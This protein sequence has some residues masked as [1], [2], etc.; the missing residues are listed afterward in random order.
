MKKIKPGKSN[1]KHKLVVRFKEITSLKTFK[2]ITS[3]LR[4][5]RQRV[6]QRSGGEHSRHGEKHIQRP[7]GGNGLGV[8]GKFKGQGCCCEEKEKKEKEEKKM[9]KEKKKRRKGGRR[10]A[11]EELPVAPRIPIQFFPPA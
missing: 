7:W 9:K 8:F 11:S 1:E 4:L 6:S 10:R 2:E 3:E 5:K